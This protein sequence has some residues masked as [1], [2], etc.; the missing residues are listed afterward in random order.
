[1]SEKKIIYCKNIEEQKQ[2][3]E[4]YINTHIEAVKQCYST[5]YKAFKEVFP[6]IFSDNA[7]IMILDIAL[8]SH[9]E[10]K[11]IIDE[12]KPYANRFFPLEGTDPNSEIVKKEFEYAWFIHL[13]NN[14][15]HPAFWAYVDDGIIKITDMPDI[16]IIEMLCDW[17]AMSK[18]YNSSTLDYWKSESAQKLPMSDYTKSKINEFMEWMQKNNESTLW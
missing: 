10:S 9:D 5:A 4:E 13:R 18:Y 1:M 15:H 7:D 2:K 11:F 3:Y 17:M 12:F 8:S 16:Y 14:P 6:D